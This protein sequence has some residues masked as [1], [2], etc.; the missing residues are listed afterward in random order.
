MVDAPK[1]WQ[2]L[3]GSEIALLDLY[4]DASGPSADDEERMFARLRATIEVEAEL[5]GPEPLAEDVYERAPRKDRSRMGSVTTAVVGAVAFA[6]GIALTL[7]LRPAT[8]APAGSGTQTTTAAVHPGEHDEDVSPGDPPTSC[9]PRIVERPVYVPAEGEFEPD[10]DAAA[11]LRGPRM[12]SPTPPPEG[13]VAG[14]ISSADG[15]D[16]LADDH[17]NRRRRTTNPSGVERPRRGMGRGG[18]TRPRRHDR[19]RTW[20]PYVPGP[21]ASGLPS[22]GPS[23]PPS[24]DM[25][26]HGT[27][28]ATNGGGQAGTNDASPNPSGRSGSGGSDNSGPSDDS[29]PP[30]APGDASP[31]DDPGPEPASEDPPDG[32]PTNDEP[33]PEDP[34]ADDDASAPELFCE[35]QLTTCHESQFAYCEWNPEACH[36]YPEFCDFNF[37]Q[38][39]TGGPQYPPDEPLAPETCEQDYESCMSELDD[40]CIDDQIPADECNVHQWHCETMLA[41][42]MGDE[43]PPPPSD[44]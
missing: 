11:P 27:T 23:A 7:G 3:E 4:R 40:L 36:F 44:W 8:D 32:Q 15:S 16:W 18:N 25:G 41:D 33:S 37:E 38:C 42:C 17:V 20:R 28:S 19:G 29:A 10:H 35:E 30:P 34:P 12:Q 5:T 6:A 39:M 2:E 24:I 26:G 21:S 22:G 9:E 1:D 14:R 13:R 31:S 43:P